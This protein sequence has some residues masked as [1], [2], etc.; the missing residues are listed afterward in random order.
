MTSSNTYWLK[1]VMDHDIPALEGLYRA[2]FWVFHAQIVSFMQ[3]FFASKIRGVDP[4]WNHYFLDGIRFIQST[5]LDIEV[6]LWLPRGIF[7]DTV[8]GCSNV[9]LCEFSS[10]LV[11]LFWHLFDISLRSLSSCWTQSWKPESSQCTANLRYLLNQ[12][13]CPKEWAVGSW[14]PVQYSAIA[15][16]TWWKHVKKLSGS[17]HSSSSSRRPKVLQISLVWMSLTLRS[18]QKLSHSKFS[19]QTY[20]LALCVLSLQ[21]DTCGHHCFVGELICATL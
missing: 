12:Q 20:V 14:Q 11:T 3:H 6:E 16:E 21:K 8:S 5:W 4:L 13:R 10:S 19:G 15:V 1:E 18:F 2:Y 9:G 17:S 7:F